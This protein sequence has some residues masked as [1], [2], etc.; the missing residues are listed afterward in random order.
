M[1]DAAGFFA[2]PAASMTL[3]TRN[4]LIMLFILAFPFVVI[5]GFLILEHFHPTPAT[6]PPALTDTNFIHSPR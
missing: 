2:N 5:T 6:P 4:R 1:I 3:K